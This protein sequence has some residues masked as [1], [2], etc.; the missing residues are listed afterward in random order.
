[1]LILCVPKVLVSHEM[2]AKGV[3]HRCA[4]SGGPYAAQDHRAIAHAAR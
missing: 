1:M 4:A 3:K 2:M